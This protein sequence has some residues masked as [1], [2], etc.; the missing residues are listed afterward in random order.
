MILQSLRVA[1]VEAWCKS[2]RI[3]LVFRTLAL[4]SRFLGQMTH[5]N[6]LLVKGLRRVLTLLVLLGRVG[7]SWPDLVV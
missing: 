4:V 1:L 7:N 2:D 3:S 6:F 5:L